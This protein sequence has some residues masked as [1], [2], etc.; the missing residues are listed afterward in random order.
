VEREPYSELAEY[1][2]KT[3]KC[4]LLNLFQ[5]KAVSIVQRP[6][7]NA[8]K[9]EKSLYIHCEVLRDFLCGVI[10]LGEKN[11]VPIHY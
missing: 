4:L 9:E 3:V 10:A 1:Y 5:E 7:Q 8:E 6:W 11:L 2:P